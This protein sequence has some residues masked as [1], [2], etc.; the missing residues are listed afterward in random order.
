MKESI[1]GTAHRGAQ[2]DLRRLFLSV[3]LNR[4]GELSRPPNQ[5]VVHHSIHF[6]SLGQK[7]FQFALLT[8]H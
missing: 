5:I 4:H 1:V 6:F 2:F 7:L 8:N 3:L